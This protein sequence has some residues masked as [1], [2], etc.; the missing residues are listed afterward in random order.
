MR[1]LSV[2]FLPSLTTPEELAGGTVV[3]IDVLR[4]S[5]TII[6]ALAA[7]AKCVIPCL[8]VEEA[9]TLAAKFPRDAIVLGGERA[10][11]KIEGFDLGNSPREYDAK[12]VGGKTVLFT[13]TNGTKAMNACKLAK[14]VLIGGFVN[15]HAVLLA[16][17]S[18]SKIHLLC[19]GTNGQITRE[20]VLC[21][22]WYVAAC[23][24]AAFHFGW[25]EVNDEGAIAR[26]TA[27]WSNAGPLYWDLVQEVAGN[28]PRS[29]GSELDRRQIR[30]SDN[31]L[32]RLMQSRGGRNLLE[33]DLAQDIADAAQLNRFAI[34]PELDLGSWRI[35][36]EPVAAG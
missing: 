8:E 6:H 28:T 12:A 25:P 17:A 32:S 4:A 13:T 11:V 33:L 23:R 36:A 2:H 29:T 24:A 1:T 15:M 14:R 9:K 34:L 16:T 26:K 31:L 20:D 21:A 27:A 10:G 35:T 3:V 7:G 18:D 19:A 5:T 30:D 22:G